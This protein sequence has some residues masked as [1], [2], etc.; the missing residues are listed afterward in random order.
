LA[1]A[2][3]EARDISDVARRDAEQLPATANVVA[4]E[5]Q[6]Q[7]EAAEAE[8]EPPAE[9]VAEAEAAEPEPEA[10]ESAPEGGFTPPPTSLEDLA[11]ASRPTKFSIRNRMGK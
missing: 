4:A 1:Q 7:P 5:P 9:P 10:A 8:P 11:A 6:P 3:V 2:G